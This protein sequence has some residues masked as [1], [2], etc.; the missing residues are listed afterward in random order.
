MLVKNTAVPSGA[1]MSWST[2][3]LDATAW[4]LQATATLSAVWQSVPDHN[5]LQQ[6][7]HALHNI[8]FNHGHH[9]SAFPKGAP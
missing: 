9:L 1:E 8:L 5:P 4:A 7:S 3:I 2:A 6:G